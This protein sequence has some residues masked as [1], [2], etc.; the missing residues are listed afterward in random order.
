M[1]ARTLDLI[2]LP[3]LAFTRCGKRLG[4]GGG[5]YDRYLLRA[6]QAELIALAFAEQLCDDLPTDSHDRRVAH[7]FVD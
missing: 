7:V 1:E 2:I 3:G 6:P 4:Y 5:Y